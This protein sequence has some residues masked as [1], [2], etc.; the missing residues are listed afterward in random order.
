M[1]IIIKVTMIFVSLF[2]VQREE[3]DKHFQS[4]VT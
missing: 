3:D 2:D 4:I 1:I